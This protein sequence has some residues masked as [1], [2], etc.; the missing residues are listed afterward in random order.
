VLGPARL[1]EPPDNL[2]CIY[3]G[4]VRG[5]VSIARL[6]AQQPSPI[7]LILHPVLAFQCPSVLPYTFIDFFLL[8]HFL[9]SLSYNG[10]LSFQKERG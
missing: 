4:G 8:L 5:T 10:I 6:A 7:H 2:S 9:L 3:S 1:G